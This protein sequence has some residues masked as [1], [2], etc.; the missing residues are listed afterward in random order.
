MSVWFWVA[1]YL[2]ITIYFYI[3]YRTFI[4]HNDRN[5]MSVI[6]WLLSPIVIWLYPLA[7]RKTK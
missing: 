7:V 2:L 3:G 1:L 4:F 5:W 6:L